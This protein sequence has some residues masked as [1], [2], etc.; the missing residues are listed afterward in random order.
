MSKLEVIYADDI[1]PGGDSVAAAIKHLQV[2]DSSTIEPD[3]DDRVHALEG[4]GGLGLSEE[5][6]LRLHALPAVSGL[7]E[8][9]RREVRALIAKECH[10]LLAHPNLLHY[11]QDGVLRWESIKHDE[12]YTRGKHQRNGDCSSTHTQLLRVALRHFGVQKDLVNGQHWLW[13]FTGTI[14]AHGKPVRHLENIRI[15]D[16]VLYG[17]S[18]G[19]T[20][21]VATSL[22]GRLVFSHGSDGGPYLLDIDYR[23]DR[24]AIRRN[25]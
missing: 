20:E 14:V 23:D 21:H 12:R 5:D 17:A 9:H 11:T 19:E 25:I 10:W 7:S 22:G 13:G 1:E 2:T 6:Q 18:V 8:Q 15:G 24:V 16:P 4:D 3:H